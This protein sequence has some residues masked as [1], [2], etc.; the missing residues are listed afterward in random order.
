MAIVTINMRNGRS[1]E[2]KR[3][4]AS[5][6]LDVMSNATGEPRGNV[7]LVIQ[8]SRGINFVEDGHHLPDFGA[9]AAE[10]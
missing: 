7:F 6:L 4:F 2:Q 1:D 10:F 8:E 5:S 9:P 3:R